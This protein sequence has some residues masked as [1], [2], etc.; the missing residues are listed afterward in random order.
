MMTYITSQDEEDYEDDGNLGLILS[1]II[2]RMGSYPSTPLVIRTDP[3][4]FFKAF[5][6]CSGQASFHYS[7]QSS[8]LNIKFLQT[9]LRNPMGKTIS[10][11][12][13]MY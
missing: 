4:V 6:S 5:L 10:E 8:I 11:R 3:G 12:S 7:V 9:R 2:S 13:F 1:T